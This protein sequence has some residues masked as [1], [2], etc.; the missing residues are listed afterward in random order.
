MGDSAA[1]ERG[2][3]RGNGGHAGVLHPPMRPGMP[4][5]LSGRGIETAGPGD[6]CADP[7]QPARV[8][9]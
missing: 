6:P 3:C 8:D 5:G 9:Y 1:R 7:G 2:L 4:R